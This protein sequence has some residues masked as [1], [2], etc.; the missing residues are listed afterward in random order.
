MDRIVSK[1]K[2]ITPLSSDIAELLLLQQVW[3]DN[4]PVHAYMLKG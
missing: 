2:T 4:S 1:S 3:G